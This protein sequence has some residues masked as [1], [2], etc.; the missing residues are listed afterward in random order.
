MTPVVLGY[1]LTYHNDLGVTHTVCIFVNTTDPDVAKLTEVHRG[2]LDAMAEEM[3]LAGMEIMSLQRMEFG[4]HDL[5]APRHT[6]TAVDTLA[7]H[8]EPMGRG[9]RRGGHTDT[10]LRLVH[11]AYSDLS[12]R[13]EEMDADTFWDLDLR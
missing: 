13:V 7:H 9:R 12:P 1:E 2:I 8:I 10:H 11:D 3:R 4:M 5:L 6:G